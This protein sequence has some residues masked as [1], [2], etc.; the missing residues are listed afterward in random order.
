MRKMRL[1]K[2][3]LKTFPIFT[4]SHLPTFISNFPTCYL[5]LRGRSLWDEWL[6]RTFSKSWHCK[7]RGEGGTV[8]FLADLTRCPQNISM[9]HLLTIIEHFPNQLSFTPQKKFL[10]LQYPYLSIMRFKNKRFWSCQDPDHFAKEKEVWS[11]ATNLDENYL[12]SFSS[13]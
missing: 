12:F 11:L 8:D 10:S 5:Y 6:L 9:Y 3:F 7:E 1:S 2:K 4:F 13:F